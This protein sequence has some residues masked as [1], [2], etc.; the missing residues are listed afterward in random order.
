YYKIISNF[1]SL[2]DNKNLGVTYTN[3]GIVYLNMKDFP[4]AEDCFRQSIVYAEKSGDKAG[5][6]SNYMYMGSTFEDKGYQ[7]DSTIYYKEKAIDIF[8]ELKMEEM[9]M[10]VKRGLSRTYTQKGDYRRAYQLITEQ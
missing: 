9:V 6:A 8:R 10:H 4:K 3:L 7:I 2:G 5:L 1:E